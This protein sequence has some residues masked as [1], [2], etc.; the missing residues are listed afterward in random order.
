MNVIW[1][2]PQIEVIAIKRSKICDDCDKVRWACGVAICSVCN[3]PLT[4]K[5]RSLSEECPEGLWE[6]ENVTTHV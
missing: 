2:D 5:C 1:P 4:A 6:K 3:C